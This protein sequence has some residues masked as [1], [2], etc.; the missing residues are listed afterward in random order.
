MV[1]WRQGRSLPYGDGV[2]FWA[3]GEIVKANAGILA[4]DPAA[5]VEEKLRIAVEYVVTDANEARWIEG[6][7]GAAGRAHLCAR[8][9]RRP[10]HRGV[11]GLAPVPGADRGAEPAGAGVRG[12]PL[13]RRRPA[14]VHHRPPRRPLHRAAAGGR[15]QPAGAAR[16]AAAVGRR[17]PQHDARAAAVVGSGDGRGWSPTCWTRRSCRRSCARRCWPAPAATRCSPRSTCGCCSTAGC[18]AARAR[19]RS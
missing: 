19:G 17:S 18:C 15:H 16:P 4:T 14:R 12:H 11:R 13:G 5:N 10:P 7:P 1:F 8:A 3:L 6:A 9:A 2:T